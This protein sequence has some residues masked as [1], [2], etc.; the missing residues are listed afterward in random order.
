MNDTP[1]EYALGLMA[2]F[3][4]RTFRHDLIDL[5]KNNAKQCVYISVEESIRAIRLEGITASDM[6]NF[7]EE[8]KIELEKL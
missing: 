2:K 7:Y 5:G 4:D 1:K 8:A 3:W 6:I